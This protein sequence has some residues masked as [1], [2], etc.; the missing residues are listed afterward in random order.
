MRQFTVEPVPMPTIVSGAMSSS[1]A[2]AAR[3]FFAS[4]AAVMVRPSLIRRVPETTVP[5]SA[6]GT[7][8]EFDSAA[9]FRDR[10]VKAY[11]FLAAFFLAFFF[12]F[13]ML[14]LQLTG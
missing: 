7:V 14:A 1:A 11:F 6:A 13:A 9:T 5:A 2:S 12:A 4:T 8:F 3:R 10:R